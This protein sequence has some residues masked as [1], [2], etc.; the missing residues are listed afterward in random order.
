M[1]RWQS[2]REGRIVKTPAK[3]A[4][5]INRCIQC[6]RLQIRVQTALRQELCFSRQHLQVVADA[7]AIAK[8]R[9][10]VG[11]LGSR[12]AF[13]LLHLLLVDAV[14]GRQLIDDLTQTIRDS[15]VVLLNRNVIFRIPSR[16]VPT[17]LTRIE[18]RQRHSRTDTDLTVARGDQTSGTE[19]L[20]TN[21]RRQ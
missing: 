12:K 6:A 8:C 2:L 10:I 4:G 5:Q 15:L 1:L 11:I 21:K 13:T 7:F 9:E 20:I 19:D 16:K 14:E 3:S 18:D 17:A